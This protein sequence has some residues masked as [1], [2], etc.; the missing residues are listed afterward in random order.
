MKQ[1]VESFLNEQLN[2]ELYSAYLYLSVA[3]YFGS[4]DLQGLAGWATAQ[5]QE[6]LRHA[7]RVR[8]HL[9]DSDAAVELREINAPA[10]D[11]SSPADALETAYEHERGLEAAFSGGLEL[12][13]EEK[14]FLTEPLIQYFLAQQMEDVVV[15]GRLLK[16]VR[17]VADSA[18]GLLV[19]DGQLANS[20]TPGSRG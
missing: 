18:T 9:M 6:E 16:K 14:D 2:R 13:R 15:V 4:L 11:W 5:S 1:A 10:Q 17:M 19:L 3:T 20:P 8:E 7:M 12:V